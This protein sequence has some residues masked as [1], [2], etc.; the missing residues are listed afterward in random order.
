VDR[1]SDAR[2]AGTAGFAGDEEKPVTAG[3]A[4][5]FGSLAGA[6][7]PGRG[8]LADPVT[9]GGV[10]TGAVPAARSGRGTMTWPPHF[11]QPNC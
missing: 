4:A 6:A 5:A 9:T 11:G 2:P 8:L 10:E 3:A 7:S 1:F